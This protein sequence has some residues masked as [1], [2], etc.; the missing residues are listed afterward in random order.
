MLLRCYPRT[1]HNHNMKK[2]FRILFILAIIGTVGFF[3]ISATNKGMKCVDYFN[4]DLATYQSHHKPVT[5]WYYSVETS[6]VD[7]DK[8]FIIGRNIQ[9]VMKTVKNAEVSISLEPNDKLREIE[10]PAKKVGLKAGALF[11]TVKTVD[12]VP[13]LIYFPNE[14]EVIKSMIHAHDTPAT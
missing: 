10:V 2:A 3:G 14:R 11:F 8:T 4:G 6:S 5:N 7:G 9:P 1:L 12:G 13:T